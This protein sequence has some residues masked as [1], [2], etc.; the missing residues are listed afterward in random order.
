MRRV[1]G[2][3]VAMDLLILRRREPG[4]DVNGESWLETASVATPDGPVQINEVFAEHPEWVLGQLRAEHGQYGQD[5]VEVR[6]FDGPLAPRLDAALG[7]IVAAAGASGLRVTAR[8]AVAAGADVG[9]GEAVYDA[10]VGPH[11]VER[12]LLRRA[13]GEFAMVRDGITV[14][15]RPPR[16]QAGELGI[17]IDMRDT[18][19]ELVDAQVAMSD[20]EGWQASRVR[21]NELY[22]RYS[23][24][25]GPV[26][27]YKETRTGRRDDEGNEIMARRSPPMGGFGKDPGLAVVRALENFDDD[28]KTAT[29]AAIFERRVI[30]P[31]RLNE[32]AETPQDALA[33]CLDERGDVDMATIGRLLGCTPADA[34]RQLG[35]LVYDDPAGGPTL[36]AAQYLS[37]NVRARIAVARAA[38]GEDPRWQVNLDALEAVQPRDLEPGEIDARLGAVW[39]PVSDVK[40]FCREVLKADVMV[41]YSAATGE[42]GFR[43]DSGM[44]KSVT[45]TSQWGTER[46]NGVRIVAANANQVVVN[47]VDVDEDGGRIPN[48]TE[49]LAAREKQEAVAERFSEWV[50]EDPDRSARLAA[51]YNVRFNS[52]VLPTYDGSHLT[53]P[54]MAENFRPHPHQRNVAWRMLSEPTVL[55]AHGVGA[56]KTASM[57]IGGREL[58][59][60]GMINKPVY[61]VPNHMLEQFSREYLQLY[62]QAKILVGSKSEVDTAHRKEF[63]ARCAADDW[64]AVIMTHSSFTKIP[65]SVATEQ[66]FLDARV[67]ELRAAIGASDKNGV[68][69]KQLQKTLAR[70]EE[71]HKALLASDRDEG[72]VTFESASIDYIVCDECQAHKNLAVTSHIRSV[73]SDGSQIAEDLAMK[74]DWLRSQGGRRLATFA[75][76][77]PIT[78]TIAEM[79]KMQKYLQPEAL[80]AAGVDHFDGWAANFGRM[81]TALELA[82]DATTYRMNTRFAR[83]ANVP[84]LLRLFREIADVRTGDE[85]HLDVPDLAGGK[86]ETVVVPASDTLVEYMATLVERSEAIHN[87]LVK[88]E[89]D[90][91]LLVTGDGRKAALDLRLVGLPP[92]PA[93]G[94]IA[95]AADQIA[96]IAVEH[97]DRP[98]MDATGARADRRGALQIVFLDLGSPHP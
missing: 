36:T 83:F 11:H 23:R 21:L 42:W 56:G 24:V 93:G 53:L 10:E 70:A 26:G 90:M 50:W 43:L 86:A 73:S 78:N 4:A 88:P 47:V 55:M 64:D 22:D 15:H 2:T 39:I 16:A 33:M 91:M 5:D 51:D 76:A 57:I 30:S 7:E 13:N 19:F 18:Y 84:D 44:A 85:L 41:E 28:T 45:L 40:A 34:R 17:L 9:I 89:E 14:A 29:K 31:R 35:T 27:R 20:D 74:L 77:T 37:G 63:V 52:V 87:G 92:D 58:K 65:V 72:G 60:L 38:A 94:K 12:S 81:V 71:R 95:A 68:T 46:V 69:V 59:R 1:A 8:P 6:A 54:G 66:A 3:G 32:S 49:T 48:L 96:A 62:P 75:T 25:Y 80:E 61:V 79:Y 97:Q 82:P 98:Y 67:D